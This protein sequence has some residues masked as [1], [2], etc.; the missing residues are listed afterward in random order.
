M[1]QLKRMPRPFPKLRIKRKV[2]SIDDFKLEDFELI[3]YDPHKK[4][5]M[6]MAV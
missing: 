6:D 4:I 1:V 5:A 3:G 2:E